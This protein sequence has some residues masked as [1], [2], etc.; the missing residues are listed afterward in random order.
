MTSISEIIKTHETAYLE[1]ITEYERVKELYTKTQFD[2][3]TAQEAA[4]TAFKKLSNVK[5]QFLVGI[6]NSKNVEKSGAPVEAT[7]GSTLSKIEDEK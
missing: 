1:K 2:L 5:E 3:M 7:S 6:I 4:F